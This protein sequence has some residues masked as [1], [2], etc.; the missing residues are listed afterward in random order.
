LTGRRGGVEVLPNNKSTSARP[1]RLKLFSLGIYLNSFRTSPPELVLCGN[2][3][4]GG[5]G[6]KRVAEGNRKGSAKELSRLLCSCLVHPLFLDKARINGR[7]GKKKK[8][9]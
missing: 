7:Q 3:S 6:R 2:K 5:N 8:K 1:R 9:S 4:V